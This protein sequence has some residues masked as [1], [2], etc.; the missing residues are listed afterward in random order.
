MEKNT[1][2][3]EKRKHERVDVVIKI[4]FTPLNEKEISSL[5][6]KE[7]YQSVDS[8]VLS[9]FSKQEKTLEAITQDIGSGGI[10]IV[11]NTPLFFGQKLLIEMVLPNARRTLRALVRV[12]R[13]QEDRGKAAPA[14]RAAI[15]IISIN[16]ADLEDLERFV[17]NQ[18]MKDILK[19]MT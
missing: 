13:V 7:N 3:L 8:T 6:I 9:E 12:V 17:Q 16:Q 1:G 18:I 4:K 19:K 5:N 2:W 15:Q 14:Y 10:M 11:S